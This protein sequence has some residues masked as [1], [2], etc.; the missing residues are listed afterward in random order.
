MASSPAPRI[1]YAQARAFY[2]RCGRWLDLQRCLEDAAF[3]DL[4]AHADFA[5]AKRVVEFGCGT[6]RLAQRLLARELPPHAHYVGFDLSTTMLRVSRSRLARFRARAQVLPLSGPP[7]LPL[8]PGSCDR[9]LATYVL[10]LLTPADAE[11]VIRQAL[12]LLAPGG[13][14]CATVMAAHSGLPNRAFRSVW[15]A[16]H[17]LS[18]LFVGGTQPA[19]ARAWLSAGWELRHCRLVCRFAVCSQVLVAVRR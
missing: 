1:S 6:G 12:R 17:R 13:L 10:D 15:T 9:F 11:A 8:A 2:D 16:L 14:L 19:D 18:P 7:R 5:D 3:A 4:L